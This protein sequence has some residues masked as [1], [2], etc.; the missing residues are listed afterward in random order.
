MATK[1]GLVH[2]IM[3]AFTGVVRDSP[4]K[5]N[6]WLVATPVNPQKRKRGMSRNL[7]ISKNLNETKKNRAKAPDTRRT[8]NALGPMGLGMTH[9]A[10]R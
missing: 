4:L 6:N 3:E 9:F 10:M 8:M 2:M 7:G 1:I 5:K